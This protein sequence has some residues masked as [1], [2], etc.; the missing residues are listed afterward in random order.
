MKKINFKSLF[1]LFALFGA[2]SMYAK[3]I[4][5]QVVV[6]SCGSIAKVSADASINEILKVYDALEG[7]C[8]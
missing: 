3:N 7:A 4:A 5:Y 8:H 2:T 1:L 6:S